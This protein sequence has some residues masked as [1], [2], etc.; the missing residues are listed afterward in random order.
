[1]RQIT[2][3]MTD[4]MYTALNELAAIA[5]QPENEERVAQFIQSSI[6]LYEWVLYQQLHGRTL[7]V[8]QPDDKKLLEERRILDGERNVI[9]Q[10][11]PED[12]RKRLLTYFEQ[13]AKAA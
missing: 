9:G 12:Q 4:D 7:V 2:L 11:F 6:R 1:M 8:L 13:V 3:D 5:E 10:F